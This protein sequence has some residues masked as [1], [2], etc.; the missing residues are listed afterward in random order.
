MLLYIGNLGLEVREMR[1]K[2]LGLLAVA[3]GLGFAQAASAADMPARMP[4]KAAPMVV[5]PYNWTGLYIGVNGGGA[6]DHVN[7]DF[8]TFATS[9][10]HDGSG[11]FAGGQIGYNW[12]MNTWVF[13]VELDGDWAS[14][15]GSV[16]CPNPVFTC[17]HEVQGLAT[18]RGRIG[19][20]MIDPR[21]LAYFTGGGAWGHVRYD[22][23]VT[24]TGLSPVGQPHASADQYG[25]TV[26][27]G[28]EYA[29]LPRWSAKAEYLYYDLGSHT[30]SGPQLDGISP[31]AVHPTIHAVR[32]GINYRLMP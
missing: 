11:G 25:W 22:E 16:A 4:A 17:G 23:F 1:N 6:W 29:F 21:L 19:T 13:G 7:W 3:L 24:A 2:I 32:F 26:G 9:A 10:P 30:F 14:I 8:P 20:T 15:K 28:L 27:G 5:A 12:Q 31:A 18:L